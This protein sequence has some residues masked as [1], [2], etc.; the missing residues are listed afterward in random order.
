VSGRELVAACLEVLAYDHIFV[1]AVVVVLV[2]GH[3]F[4]TGVVV[5]LVLVS[6][7]DVLQASTIV[8]SSLI[9]CSPSTTFTYWPSI[10]KVLLPMQ[11]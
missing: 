1:A 3:I 11:P 7:R 9:K 5:I 6:S 10:K 8:H 4:V 2:S